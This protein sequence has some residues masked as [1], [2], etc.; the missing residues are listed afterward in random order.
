M[1]HGR[2]RAFLA[3]C[4][5]LVSLLIVSAACVGEDSSGFSVRRIGK[6][7]SFAQNAFEVDAPESGTLTISVCNDTSVFRVL[8]RVVPAGTTR[9]EWDGCGYN[10]ERLTTISYHIRCRLAGDSGKEYNLSFDSPV[11]YT[12]QALQFALESADTVSLAAPADWFMELKT[13][14]NGTVSVEFLPEGAGEPAYVFR[15][16]VS[17]GRITHMTFRQVV[18]NAE[19]EP[20]RYRVR[21]YEI[22]SPGYSA[23]FSLNVTADAPAAQ[24]IFLTGS[25]MPPENASDEEIWEMMMRPSVVVDIGYTDHQ[26]VYEEP[27]GESRVLGTLHGQTQALE[28]L[29]IGEKWVLVH[30]WNHEQGE[31][32]TGWVPRAKLKV[33]YPSGRYGILID[34][35]SQTLS[36]Y[37]NGKMIETLMVSTGRMEKGALYQETAAGSFLTGLHR[38]DYSTNGNRY[39]YVIQYDGGNLIHQIPYRHGNGKKLFSEGEGFLGAKASHACV[40]VQALPGAA[41]GLNAYWLWTHIPYHTRVIILDDP[42]QRSGQMAILDGTAAEQSLPAVRDELFDDPRL[43]RENQ[44]LM[45]FGGDAVLGGRESYFRRSDSLFAYLDKYGMEYP[46]SGLQAYFASDDLTSVNLECVLKDNANGEDKKKEWRFRGLPEYTGIL[47]KGSV[48]LVNTANNH[49]IDYGP[50]GYESTIRALEGV[51]NWCG[52]EHPA[53]V[54]VRGHLIGFGGCR[55]TTYR[56]DPGVVERDIRALREMGCELIVYQCHWGTE[57]DPNH[58]A[59]QEAM[60][61]ACVRSGADLVI[62]HHPH[63]VQGIEYYE[64]VPIVYSLGNL[65]FGGTISLKDYDA[66]LLQ[67]LITFDGESPRVEVRPVPIRTSSAA[68]AKVNDFHP[69]PAEGEQYTAIMNRIQSDSV[70]PEP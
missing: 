46:F 12:A 43:R 28:V 7:I 9:I 65:V 44:V 67:A 37:E 17:T 10:R 29:E 48:E 3:G 62:G 38:V 18:G 66:M 58:N 61:R 60:A 35:V 24:D 68:D 26:R 33:E 6:I 14:Q 2:A 70:L 53:A 49:T 69:V 30:A 27:D 1:R 54:S 19:I 32:V 21:V 34:K 40:R 45:T 31:E 36:V 39:D 23:E 57:Y 11:E 55:E 22:S 51:V 4:I 15:R 50:E 5:L 63:I 16:T 8:T 59:Q 52:P 64:G 47:T 41:S 56:E 20:G 42:V 13:I 25:V